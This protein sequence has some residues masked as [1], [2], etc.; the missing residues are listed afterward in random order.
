MSALSLASAAKQSSAQAQKRL[1]VQCMRPP[2]GRSEGEHSLPPSGSEAAV[3][4]A[5]VYSESLSS[6]LRALVPK[7]H[8]CPPLGSEG[9]STPAALRHPGPHL[10]HCPPS[11][12]GTFGG[13]TRPTG[14]LPLW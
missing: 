8:P 4:L 7:V 9:P 1:A 13:C 14:C 11:A 5:A 3:D 6:A 2:A 12:A 10:H